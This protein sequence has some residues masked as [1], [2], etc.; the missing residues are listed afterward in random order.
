[1][2]RNLTPVVAPIAALNNVV[3]PLWMLAFG[4]VLVTTAR[5]EK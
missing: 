4:L 3:L 5:T 1:M 2:L